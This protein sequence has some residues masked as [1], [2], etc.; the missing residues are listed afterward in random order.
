M[1]EKAYNT[2]SST[3]PRI[4]SPTELPRIDTEEQKVVESHDEDNEVGIVNMEG[5]ESDCDDEEDDNIIEQDTILDDWTIV[6][7]ELD[8]KMSKN[9]M[10]PFISLN[11]LWH[12]I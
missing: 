2:A 5:I 9:T 3:R 11:R 1:D 8:R 6:L 10:H 7:D 4:I 12:Y